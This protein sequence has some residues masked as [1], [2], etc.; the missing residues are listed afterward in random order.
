MKP[1]LL[2]PLFVITTALSTGLSLPSF[3]SESATANQYAADS[4]KG[5]P[6]S[7]QLST[8]M[9]QVQAMHAQLLQRVREQGKQRA[10]KAAFSLALLSLENDD[11]GKA[12]ELL[13]EAVMLQPRNTD[14][15]RAASRMAF[16]LNNYQAAEA[17]LLSMA[18]IYRRASDTDGTKLI[19]VIDD[20]ATL[21][22]AQGR[23]SASR[24]ALIEGL[25]ARTELYGE[26]DPR[27]V[28]NLYR[29]AELELASANAGAAKDQLAR[30]IR[31]LDD[32]P[33]AIGDHEGAA[34]LHNIGEL[35]RVSRQYP[36]AESAYTKAMALWNSSP[37]RNL[38]GIAMT[39]AS[40]ARLR[41]ARSAA[42]TTVNPD[43]DQPR[44][45][46]PAVS[47]LVAESARKQL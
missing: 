43:H 4:E 2:Y 31:I 41:T 20:L 13:G 1:K 11:R 47:S 26:Y 22:L 9:N 33:A 40:L 24:S 44:Q 19:G 45:G 30:A 28:D 17:Y 32:S 25:A 37:V 23:R 36:E 27:L 34:L 15:L 8:G 6:G 29:L 39:Q 3:G 10:A 35:L 12:A 18:G 7:Q 42:S 14:Y 21:Y 38:R 16:E 46:A 5:P